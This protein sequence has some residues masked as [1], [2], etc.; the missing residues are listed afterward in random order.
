MAR[1]G[2]DNRKHKGLGN[3]LHHQKAV[4]QRIARLPNEEQ[5]KDKRAHIQTIQEGD[6]KAAEH[7]R[8][9]RMEQRTD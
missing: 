6:S 4:N 9:L 8:R 7:A 3:K 1:H 5:G 2:G